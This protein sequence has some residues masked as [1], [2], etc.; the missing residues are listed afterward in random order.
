MSIVEGRHLYWKTDVSNWQCHR[1]KFYHFT[2]IVAEIMIQTFP[3]KG[4]HI[5]LKEFFFVSLIENVCMRAL[6][7]VFTRRPASIEGYWIVHLLL[8]KI[9][10]H[11]KLHIK[12]DFPYWPRLKICIQAM[13]VGHWERPSRRSW[14]RFVLLWQ[15]MP[16]AHSELKS[17]VGP[18]KSAR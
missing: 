6:F 9:L 10:K 17:L 16:P 5:L 18:S 15:W 8:W 3:Q 2:K 12:L 13:E 14:M 7:N 4:F 1:A 11:F